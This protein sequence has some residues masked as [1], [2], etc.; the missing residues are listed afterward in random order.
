MKSLSKFFTPP[1]YESDRREIYRKF[2]LESLEYFYTEK[3]GDQL[4]SRRLCLGGK[5]TPRLNPPIG[6]SFKPQVTVHHRFHPPYVE[7]LNRGL[8][9]WEDLFPFPFN[10][11]ALLFLNNTDFNIEVS[12]SEFTAQLR[13][14]WGSLQRL[15]DQMA[16][17]EIS[18][19]DIRSHSEH[20]PLLVHYV[21]YRRVRVGTSEPLKQL[22]R[23]W[24]HN[25]SPEGELEKYFG[26]RVDYYP[27]N[28]ANHPAEALRPDFLTELADKIRKLSETPR[29][30]R[31]PAPS[32]APE[33]KL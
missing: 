13:R 19:L 11:L 3:W 7:P 16:Q 25:G 14:L 23:D 1:L 28:L 10:R 20:F 29:S 15:E 31:R 22:I 24:S 32:S 4:L 5:I 18:L 27:L 8:S 6:E 12:R 26:T 30:K 2:G 9:F 21:R 17:T 33:L